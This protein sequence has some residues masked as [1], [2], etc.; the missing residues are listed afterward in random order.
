[1]SDILV[2]VDGSAASRR[3]LAWA[4]EEA[5]LRGDV[6]IAVH[7]YRPPATETTQAAAYS[8][9][10][11]EDIGRVAE[12]DRMRRD[13]Q[14][15]IARSAAERLLAQTIREVAPDHGGAIL[16]QL[17]VAR[18]PARTLVEMSHQAGL[19]VVG[20]RGRG[21]FKGLLLG[22]VSQQCVHHAACPVV[23]VR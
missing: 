6:V 13:E 18:D 2:G 20:S 11:G 19:L 5:G 17:A 3:A 22:S 15:D 14:D 7:T 16:K 21:G 23:V 9:L 12:Q 10:A 1:M 8:Y 4:V